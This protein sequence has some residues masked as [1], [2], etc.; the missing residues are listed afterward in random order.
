MKRPTN[1][2]FWEDRYRKHNIF[3]F[4]LTGPEVGDTVMTPSLFT[5]VSNIC[6]TVGYMF[7]ETNMTWTEK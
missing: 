6:C 3:F 7:H 5:K 4:G 1:P 2:T